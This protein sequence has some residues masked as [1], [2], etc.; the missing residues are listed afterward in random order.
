MPTRRGASCKSLQIPAISLTTRVAAL[1][2]YDIDG[3]KIAKFAQAIEAYSAL[4]VTPRRA[5]ND[6][7]AATAGLLEAFAAADTLLR[8]CLDKLIP[9]IAA[10]HPAFGVHYHHARPIIRASSRP[11]SPGEKETPEERGSEDEER[12]MGA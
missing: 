10:R 12:G 2:D 9:V 11:R 4:L 5:I 8:D 1:A 3:E 7:K 6:R